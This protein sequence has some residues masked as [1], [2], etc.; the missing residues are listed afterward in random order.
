MSYAVDAD[1][2]VTVLYIRHVRQSTPDVL[3]LEARVEPD[4][5]G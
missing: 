2:N 4:P 5:E 3:D 1:D